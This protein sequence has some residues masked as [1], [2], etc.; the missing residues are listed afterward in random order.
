MSRKSFSLPRIDLLLYHIDK[1]V[2]KTI[3]T[4]F[5]VAQS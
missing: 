1:M 4:L 2:K 3:F 5:L